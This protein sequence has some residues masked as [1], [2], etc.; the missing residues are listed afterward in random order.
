[1]GEWVCL[2]DEKVIAGELE[3]KEYVSAVV[4]KPRGLWSFYFVESIY[5]EVLL[6]MLLRCCFCSQCL[7]SEMQL[8]REAA[9][10][11]PLP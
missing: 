5:M 7:S 9:V 6:S 3:S 8:L 10:V 11:G 1:M 4:W 2:V